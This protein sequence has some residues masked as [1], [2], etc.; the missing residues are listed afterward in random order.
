MSRWLTLGWQADKLAQLALA[1]AAVLLLNGCQFAPPQWLPWNNTADQPQSDGA[2]DEVSAPAVTQIELLGWATAE[3][4]GQPLQAL[5]EHFNTVN[6]DLRVVLNLADDY[7]LALQALSN[8]E[9]APALVLLDAPRARELMTDGQL[10]PLGA[11][12]PQAVEFYPALR[13]ALTVDGALY[14][15]P[16]EVRT[17]ALVYNRTLFDTAGVT[18]PSTAWTWDDLRL[19]A[20][21]L[22]DA[23]VALS[24]LALPPDFS[25]WLPFLY[26]AGG[27]VTDDAMSVMTVNSEAAISAMTFYTNLVIDGLAAPPADLDSVW[28]G[29]A[30]A[31]GTAAMAFEGNWIVPYLADQAPDLAYGVA[32]LPTGPVGRATLA[33]STCYAIPAAT[34][35][36]GAA[37]RLLTFLTQPENLLALSQTP[38]TMPS[39]RNGEDAWR[40]AHPEQAA[41]LNGIA[42]A[43]PWLL[44]PRFAPFFDTVNFGLQQAFLSVRSVAD[45]LAEADGIGNRALAR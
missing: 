31:R 35:Q 21:Q 27:S 45:I 34:A 2:N 9:A 18:Y 39:I 25:R 1:T 32:E 8:R 40:Q 44:G 11:L 17:L 28:A 36:P 13:A 42:Y 6:P 22:K 43:R 14:C 24:P 7:D 12:I 4:N 33:F 26:Q 5:V 29:E 20:Q 15:A 3:D 30:I 16:R 38:A 41:F 23:K 19:A 37:Q 10:T